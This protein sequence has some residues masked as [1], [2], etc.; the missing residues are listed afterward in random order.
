MIQPQRPSLCRYVERNALRAALVP[1]V[2]QWRWSEEKGVR[3]A[4]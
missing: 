1:R 3:F 2:E 4:L